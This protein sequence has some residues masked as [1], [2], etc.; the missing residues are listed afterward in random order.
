MDIFSSQPGSVVAVPSS[1]VPMATFLQGWGGYLPFKSVITGFEV[2]T[3]AGVQFMHSLRDFVYIY[4]FGERI[5]PVTFS[6]VSFAHVC[7]RLD[8]RTAFQGLPAGRSG[9]VPNFHG[10]EYVL[11]Y[12]NTNRVSTTGAPV[13]L[14]LGLNTVL[15]GF[16]LGARVGLQDSERRVANFSLQ[17]RAVPQATLLDLLL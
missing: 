12:Y 14:V 7:E 4:V 11:N 8:E 13:T 2:E 17:F 6:G 1:G 15:F 9:F 5:A 16:L 3:Q 10:L